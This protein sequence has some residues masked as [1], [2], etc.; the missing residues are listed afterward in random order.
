MKSKIIFFLPNL[1][2]GGAE[3]ITLNFIKKLDKNKF[4]VILVVISNSWDVI[5]ELPIDI[6]I[7]RFD[8]SRT[9]K[10]IFKIST[11]IKEREPDIVF[12][13]L[14]HSSMVLYLALLINMKKPKI[15][16]RSPT[17]PKLLIESGKLGSFRKQL[18][19]KT[20]KSANLLIAQTPEMKIEM[21]KYYGI[22]EE[23]IKVFINP[24]DK[25]AI[26][27]KLQ[28]IKNPFNEEKENIVASGRLVKQK[29]FDI[30]IEA[31]AL[32]YAQNKN[33]ELHILGSEMEEGNNLRELVK[34]LNLQKQ[35]HFLGHQSNPYRY[36]YF[37]D[38]YVLSSRKE[39]L[40]N[41]VLE[42]LYLKK[43]IIATRCIPFMDTL[44]KDRKNGFLVEVENIEELAE[45]ILAYKS[46]VPDDS[47]IPEQKGDINELIEGVLCV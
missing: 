3:L 33:L 40:P 30:L 47:F 44:F 17:S 8:I 20:Y 18:L 23:K 28:N 15:I 22:K 4:E 16:F 1:T 41:T 35:V 7:V 27:Q 13:S 6:E 45:K 9:I 26:N 5:E 36:Y 14:M 29:G 19:I 2:V 46:L 24:I 12:T 10:S 21:V 25:I 11:F 42:N 32:A 31:F 43:P 37:S 39:G 34:S 38:L